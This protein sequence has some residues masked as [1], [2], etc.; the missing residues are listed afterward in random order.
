MPPIAAAPAAPGADPQHAT[1]QPGKARR[2]SPTAKVAKAAA[3]AL[4]PSAAAPASPMSKPLK[5]K[6]SA[7]KL[8]AADQVT[9]ARLEMLAEILCAMFHAEAV[10][11][12]TT[13]PGAA[14]IAT[15][16]GEQLTALLA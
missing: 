7:T 12:A 11:A 2:K 15:P 6:P 3:S 1:S 13:S 4:E 8:K 10:A 5:S 16:R 9:E 14:S